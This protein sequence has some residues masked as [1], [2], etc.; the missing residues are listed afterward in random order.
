MKKAK[1]TIVIGKKTTK[2][3][4]KNISVVNIAMAIDALYSLKKEVL[5]K[6]KNKKK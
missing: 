1:I 2:I 3:K 4:V 5:E 6:I